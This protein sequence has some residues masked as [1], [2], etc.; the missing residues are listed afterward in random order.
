MK[1]LHEQAKPDARVVFTGLQSGAALQTLFRCAAF[2]VTASELE[3]LPSSLL[4][5]MDRAICPIVSDIPPHREPMEGV[6]GYD[7][8][9]Q[10]G[11]VDSLESR[12]RAMLDDPD[13]ARSLG[14]KA[15][16][17]VRKQYDWPTLAQATEKLYL[18]T[19]ERVSRR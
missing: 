2:Y 7:L 13:R 10:P 1:Q 8:F 14:E 4:E 11:D 6:E 9:F 18:R 3:G 15:R 16:A 12:L 17:Y 5:C 19:L